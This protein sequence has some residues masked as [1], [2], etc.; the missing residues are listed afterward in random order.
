MSPAAAAAGVGTASE[1][2]RRRSA[3]RQR[4][5]AACQLHRLLSKGAGAFAAF[6]LLRGLLCLIEQVRAPRRKEKSE[7]KKKKTERKKKEKKERN[8]FA[9]AIRSS[10]AHEAN[11]PAGLFS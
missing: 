5:A 11:L 7:R 10:H 6:P 9:V 2:V 1:R 3:P 8:L 4:T